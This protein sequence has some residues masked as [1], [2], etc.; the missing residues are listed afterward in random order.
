MVLLVNM[1]WCSGPVGL[2]QGSVLSPPLFIIILE[3]LPMKLR[4]EC[5]SYL[6]YAD[7]LSLL[8]RVTLG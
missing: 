3:A 6:L 2:S 5:P 1:F 8:K 7:D 4:S